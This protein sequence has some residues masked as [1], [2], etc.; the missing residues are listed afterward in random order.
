[1]LPLVIR[2]KDAEAQ[3]PMEKQYVFTQ[4]PVRIGRNQLNDISINRAFVSLFHA[5]VR[6]DKSTISV[7]DLGS[8]NGVNVR[9]K[10]IEK[11][12]PVRITPGTDVTIGSVQFHFS[13]DAK[14]VRDNSS[15]LTQFRALADIQSEA[16]SFKPTPVQER[17]V[18][19]R[20]SLL[21]SLDALLEQEAQDERGNPR[22][23]IAPMGADTSEESTS[24][25]LKTVPEPEPVEPPRPKKATSSIG[26]RKRT[27]TGNSVIPQAPGGAAALQN[28]IQQLVPL[29]NAYRTS[30]KM[31]H[32]GLS[33]GMDSLPAQDR[34]QLITQLQR[35]MPDM[36]QEPMFQE[37]ARNVGVKVEPASGPA[38]PASGGSGNRMEVVSRE[39]LNQFVRSYLPDS[40][41]LQSEKDIR[42]FLEH[43]AE[44]LE[45][46]GRAFVE[47]RQG[48][49]Q[50][51]QQMAVPVTNDE[52]PLTRMKSARELLRYV[53]DFKADEDSTRVQDLMGGFVDVMIHQIALLNG[54]REGVKGMLHRLS[55][56][57]MSEGIGGV[58]PFNLAKKWTRYSEQHHAFLEEERELTA[59]LFGPEFA[60]AYLAIVG[61]AT[62]NTSSKLGAAAADGAEQGQTEE[63]S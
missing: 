62:H 27:M 11:N 23:I 5:L 52:N 18:E 40:K 48:H 3:P 50:F 10:R 58:W 37:I 61:D 29:Y 16:L 63:E 33:Q 17:K 60:K 1:M 20:T 26:P 46:F 25:D 54:M 44:V 35:R 49:D 9:G 51:G 12:V 41:G 53:L 4:S 14:A 31:L 59:V 22:T 57:A 43:L 56:T 36:A 45:T 13:R 19:Q 55:P 8:T 28:S 30:W 21:P 32:Q 42:G 7:V 24:L 34:A 15:R 6:F 39:L 38:A 2:I 47:L